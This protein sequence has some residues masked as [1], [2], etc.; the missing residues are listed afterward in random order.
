MAEKYHDLNKYRCSTEDL[1]MQKKKTNDL[2]DKAIE[3]VQ[4]EEQKEHK[5]AEN[6]DTSKCTNLFIT[7]VPDER[8]E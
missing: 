4:S 3:I 8:Q 7:G 2:E 6:L 5:Y 1:S